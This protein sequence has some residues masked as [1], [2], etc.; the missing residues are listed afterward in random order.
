MLSEIYTLVKQPHKDINTLLHFAEKLITED[1]CDEAEQLC[2]HLISHYG[3]RS[4]LSNLL[5][6]IN[7]RSGKLLEAKKQFETAHA[8]DNNDKC[9]GVNLAK[10]LAKLG[11]TSEANKVCDTLTVH[12]PKDEEVL[13]VISEIKEDTRVNN[14]NHIYPTFKSKTLSAK[15]FKKPDYSPV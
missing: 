15:L 5:G 1:Y 10:I 9:A 14:Q 6:V 3:M 4:D 2:N 8:L 11:S 13:K 12:F 7:Y